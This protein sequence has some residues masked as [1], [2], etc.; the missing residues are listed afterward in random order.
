MIT[1][2][3]HIQQEAFEIVLDRNVPLLHVGRAEVGIGHRKIA[4]RAQVVIVQEGAR[5]FEG[6]SG[7]RVQAVAHQ[8]GRA[9]GLVTV[10]ESP[11]LVLT[12][13]VIA[14]RYSSLT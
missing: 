7:D 13:P 9:V 10:C 11:A 4:R 12:L 8:V 14:T 6:R 1:D 5:N 2:V 3:P